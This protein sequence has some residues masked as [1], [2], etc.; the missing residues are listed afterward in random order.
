MAIRDVLIALAKNQLTA[1]TPIDILIRPAIFMPETKYLSELLNEMQ[2]SGNRIALVV[3]EYGGIAGI[4]TLQQMIEEIVGQI[5]DELIHDQ[6]FKT[7]D[8]NTFEV[9][10]GMTIDGANEELGLTLPPGNYETVAGFV[11]SQLGH[12]PQKGEQIKHDKLK[13]VITNMKGLKIEK[14]RITR[15]DPDPPVAA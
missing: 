2:A 11:L 15:V 9:E 10:G 1:E 4:I 12:I 6:E 5:R 7:I 3:D 8:D 13:I 14:V